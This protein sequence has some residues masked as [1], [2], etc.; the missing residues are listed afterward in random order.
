MHG[1]GW[2]AKHCTGSTK[3]KLNVVGWLTSSVF[4]LFVFYSFRFSLLSLSFLHQAHVLREEL[5]PKNIKVTGIQVR[6]GENMLE[7][8]EERERARSCACQRKWVVGGR[9]GWRREGELVMLWYGGR[10]RRV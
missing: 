6:Y 9:G 3:P 1:R 4:F 5:A 10:C 2:S 7:G 8:A